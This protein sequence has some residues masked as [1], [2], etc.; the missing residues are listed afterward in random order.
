MF[1][2][3]ELSNVW[4]N[5]FVSAAPGNALK[6]FSKNFSVFSNNNKDLRTFAYYASRSDV[7][8]DNMNSPGYFK[9]RFMDTFVSVVYVFEHCGLYFATTACHFLASLDDALSIFFD[10]D[11]QFQLLR[12]S[13]LDMPNIPIVTFLCPPTSPVQGPA[14]LTSPDNQQE[15]TTTSI[16][17]SPTNI[18]SLYDCVKFFISP[19]DHPFRGLPQEPPTF[20]SSLFDIRSLVSCQIILH[21]ALLLTIYPLTGSILENSTPNARRNSN[22]L[23]LMNDFV[24]N[25]SQF[26]L[27]WELS[28][29]DERRLEYIFQ[30]TSVPSQRSVVSPQATTALLRE[31]LSIHQHPLSA[32][33]IF[34]PYTS[35]WVK[36][37][38]IYQ[39]LLHFYFVWKTFTNGWLLWLIY[40]WYSPNRQTSPTFSNTGH[41]AEFN[42][43]V[44]APPKELLISW[45][46]IFTAPKDPM[47][48]CHPQHN[49]LTPTE[50]KIHDFRAKG[51]PTSR[52]ASPKSNHIFTLS[53][54][55]W[56]LPSSQENHTRAPYQF[57]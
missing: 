14:T 21:L 55:F 43:R 3:S 42:T 47:S 40:R 41:S 6:K 16:P 7:L 15:M 20:I 53:I 18:P 57:S 49:S 30:P 35:K 22:D 51:K 34:G 28:F 50:P 29:W 48:V 52:F 8:V 13:G 5:I 33:P 24:I 45:T 54:T 19:S 38:L 39:P 25:S 37:S 31:C 9:D 23:D 46:S 32:L 12:H 2:G 10:A 1:T 27:S 56:N 17:N 36:S 11:D 26:F 44:T 4:D